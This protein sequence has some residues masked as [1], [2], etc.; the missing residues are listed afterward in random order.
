MLKLSKSAS[1]FCVGMEGNI[2]GRITD[3]NFLIKSSGAMLG[4]LNKSDLLEFNL[5]G[6]KLSK[7]NKNPSMEI[8][9]HIYLL[10]FKD[11]NFVSHTHPINTLKILCSGKSNDF[12]QNR[13][14]P[15]QVVFNGSKSCLVPYA[16]PG[17]KL[18]NSIKKSVELFINN[19]GNLPSLILLENHGI[20]TIGKTI[21]EC[22]MSTQICEKS[23]KIFNGL[24][25]P[26]FLSQ[27]EIN[28][29]L[30]DKKEKYR[31]SLLQ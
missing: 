9:F 12:S 5:D 17:E 10:G 26:K 2:S 6:V 11:V 18:T 14:F 22:I 19:E 30:T 15:D 21:D 20:I 25:Q 24:N 1:H 8:G 29:I 4:N 7:T 16:M 31:K 27:N 3:T 28:E 23:A 13:L